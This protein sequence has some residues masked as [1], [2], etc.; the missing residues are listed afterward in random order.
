MSKYF[1]HW[2]TADT[3]LTK[4]IAPHLGAYA[5]ADQAG[6]SLSISFL[7]LN[8]IYSVPE[9]DRETFIQQYNLFQRW[10]NDAL[11]LP[12]LLEPLLYQPICNETLAR[13]EGL[14]RGEICEYTA[15]HEIG[16]QEK[17]LEFMGIS[18]VCECIFFE[19]EY[20][21]KALQAAINAERGCL[22]NR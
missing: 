19:L 18:L 1:P 17:F 6:R 15:N 16:V 21:E 20:D 13:A 5:S 7:P 9:E 14:V 3:I 10:A 2:I 4:G 12:E 8:I 11:R 22:T